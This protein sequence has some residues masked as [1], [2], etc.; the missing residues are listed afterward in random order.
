MSP[1]AACRLET[2]GFEHVFDYVPGKM[3]WLAR[4]LPVE[5]E[6]ADARTAGALARVP[7]YRR[8]IVQLRGQLRQLAHCKGRACSAPMPPVAPPQGP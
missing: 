3:D 8:V 5:G 7:A 4:N 6:L 2:L 1:R